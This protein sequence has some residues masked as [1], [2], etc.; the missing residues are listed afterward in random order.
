[1]AV[2]NGAKLHRTSRWKT[3]TSFSLIG[4]FFFATLL[5][6]LNS[7]N[8][9][10]NQ[11]SF[12]V[13]SIVSSESQTQ[14]T[15]SSPDNSSSTSTT[16]IPPFNYTIPNDIVPPKRV[17][18]LKRNPEDRRA[19]KIIAKD[20]KE[21]FISTEAFKEYGN[22]IRYLIQTGKEQLLTGK[23]SLNPSDALAWRKRLQARAPW[24]KGN[25]ED[26]DF[27]L[28]SLPRPVDGKAVLICAGDYQLPYLRNLIHSIR[29]VHQSSI[30]IRVLYRDEN[31]LSAQSQ[32]DLFTFLPE[33]TDYN[34]QLID[35]S[36]IFD[37]DADNTNLGAGWYLKPL[38]FLAV[39]ETEVALLDVDII[40]LQPPEQL[41]ESDR[42]RNV[43]A[44]FFHDRFFTT[45]YNGWFDPGYLSKAFQPNL[46]SIGEAAI[47]YG[48]TPYIGEH[49]MES[50]VVVINKNRRVLGIWVTCFLAARKDIRDYTEIFYAYGDKE[51]YWIGFETI[52]EPYSFGK[53]LPGVYG[54]VV[55][56]YGKIAIAIKPKDDKEEAQKRLKEANENGYALCGRVLHFDDDNNPLWSNGGYFTKEEDWQSTSKLA[57]FPLNAIWFV[58]GGD[59]TT[60]QFLPRM[61]GV[62]VKLE[63]GEYG[64]PEGMAVLAQAKKDWSKA[65]A[66][67]RMNQDWKTHG[68][69]GVM[70]LH[71][72]QR[73]IRETPE[74]ST[75]IATNAAKRFFLDERGLNEKYG[76]LW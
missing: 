41:F 68:G 58:D 46:S 26:A 4:L 1:M 43:G 47:R 19:E 54:A 16:V 39:A 67:V 31:D 25:P 42:Y 65:K 12:T 50:G 34:L 74:K 24:L 38:G 27:P 48:D 56:N 32:A 71:P 52:S 2:I 21:S 13:L 8:S 7:I 5:L 45:N 59:F 64:N 76:D 17:L 57:E 70:C 73:G 37:L 66:Q 18:V 61:E 40:L 14:T 22:E 28:S 20:G 30:P 33:G 10:P 69:M 3:K 36:K 29:V 75:N 23:S 62:K 49:V 60:E 11:H 72:N 51:L 6:A 9:V 53:Y 15:R 35:L 44:S 55:T 63:N